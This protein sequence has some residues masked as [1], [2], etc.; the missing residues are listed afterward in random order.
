MLRVIPLTNFDLDWSSL[1]TILSKG[2]GRNI[3]APLDSKGKKVGDISS[4]IEILK[5]MKGTKNHGPILKHIH[6]SF[7]V[8]SDY[9]YYGED[10]QVETY[11]TEANNGLY[12]ILL[13][14]TLDRWQTAIINGCS[15]DSEFRARELMTECFKEFNRQGLSHLWNDYR[16][17]NVTDHTIKLI[18][19]K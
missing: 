8:I 13:S 15:M 10:L 1:L 7:L 9:R 3:T 2:L 4:Y 19:K 16:R 18:E 6:F 12:I 5:E 14:G 17:V 11:T